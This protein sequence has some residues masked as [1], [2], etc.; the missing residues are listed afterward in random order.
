MSLNIEL[1]SG[2]SFIA[3]CNFG[4]SGNYMQISENIYFQGKEESEESEALFGSF[5]FASI[6]LKSFKSLKRWM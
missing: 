4:R 5:G 2:P 6:V 1:S 3:K